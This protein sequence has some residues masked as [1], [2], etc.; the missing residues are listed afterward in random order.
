MGIKRRIARS[1]LLTH[2]LT[3][4]VLTSNR[5]E[6]STIRVSGWDQML[7]RSGVGLLTH[8]LTQ[9]VPISNRQENGTG[10]G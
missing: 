6:V 3:Q 1:G 4:V 10:P 8:L 7:R 9:V 2:L 5:Q